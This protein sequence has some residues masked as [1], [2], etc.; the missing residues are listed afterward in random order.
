MV[1]PK[2]I[3]VSIVIIISK[4]AT[5]SALIK[6]RRSRRHRYQHITTDLQ[7]PKINST[8]ALAHRALSGQTIVSAN[9]VLTDHTAIIK[10]LATAIPYIASKKNTP[11]RYTQ[12]VQHIKIDLGLKAHIR[13]IKPMPH[14]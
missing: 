9:R 14:A 13:D 5:T 3:V 4:Y 11:R 6:S 2:T 1:T 8:P 10:N 7:P 12:R